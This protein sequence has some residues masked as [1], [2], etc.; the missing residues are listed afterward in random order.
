[1]A[2][3]SNQAIGEETELVGRGMSWSCPS[4]PALWGRS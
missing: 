3:C 4:S 1:L 2:L